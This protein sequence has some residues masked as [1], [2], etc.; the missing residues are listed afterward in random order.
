MK[1][2]K[3]FLTFIILTL[4]TEIVLAQSTL[5]IGI[6]K[7]AESQEFN[8]AAKHIK[9]EIIALTKPRFNVTFTE[10]NGN[11]NSVEI[12]QTLQRLMKNPDINLLI[13]VG[14]ISSNE[15]SKL[16]DYPK[17]LIAASILDQSLQKL[18][19]KS[20]K[21]TGVNNFTYIESLIR[22]KDDI[23]SF[24]QMFDV[25][26]AAVIIAKPLID[27]F[28]DIVNYIAE[29]GKGLNISMI[30]ADNHCS[31]A[32][33]KLPQEVDA[34]F[35]LPLF[36]SP[37]S[38][39]E[40]LLHGLN[41]KKIP[42]LAVSGI[43]YL[44]MGATVTFTPQYNFQQLA[45]QTALRILK[46]GEGTNLSKVPVS[47]EGIQRGPVINMAGIRV[48]KRFPQW[49]YLN[50]AILINTTKF[51]SGSEKN[52]RMV[53]AEALENNLQGKISDKDLLMAEK[54][55]RIAKANIYP[56]IEI[57]G[58]AIEL[59][60]NIVE[61]AM[62][63]KG[64][65]T[66]SGS[67]MLK[68]V[69]FSEAVFANITINKLMEENKKAF[70]RQTVL[71]IISNVSNAYIGLLF[72]KSNL[73]I[74]SENVNAT[75]QNLQM[76][77]AKKK[78][79]QSGIS[80][81]NRWISELNMNKM[82]LN[83]A[84]T[85][86]RTSMYQLNQILNK[87]I[88]EGIN[89]TDYDDFDKSVVSD[90]NLLKKIFENPILTEKYAGFIIEQ[91]YLNS[92]EL[93]QL[94]TAKEIIK[95]KK[96][97]YK[98]RLYLPEVAVWGGL[99]QAFIRN[100]TIKPVGMPVPPPPDDLTWNVGLKISLP[101]YEGGRT[102]TEMQKSKIELDKIN[103]QKEDLLN[104]LEAGIRANV[105]KSRASYLELELSTNAAKAAKDNF[106]VVQ[107]GYF[108]GVT[109]LVQLI[110]AQTVMTRTKHLANIAYYQ[111]IL[112]YLQVERLQGK[113]IFLSSAD[114]RTVYTNQLKN[115]L[116]DLSKGE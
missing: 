17:P 48:I 35:V 45:R 8:Q 110:D 92:P 70:N 104:K 84:Y 105:Q 59:S 37:D 53:I 67:A 13:T 66:L 87:P 9:S 56:Q 20:D 73:Q 43:K 38:E 10:F 46:V 18:P 90:I 116:Q 61:A 55:V 103:Y 102:Y 28:P 11:W 108:Q 51:P 91:M 4:T 62:G 94:S 34:V 54:N 82:K 79:G 16:A 76:A 7:D 50:E 24:S 49:S 93:K 98:R 72:S 83:D 27:N 101:I 14:F 32:L 58:T 57:S 47:I 99:D 81:V 41:E 23:R 88:D 2:I 26:K 80:D 78:A 12:K 77:K 115:Y 33:A 68:Q 42:S 40:K 71:E 97:L 22:L 106:K 113:Y 25:H 96:S 114:E 100:G 64:A 19:L 111:F 69:I 30:T 52:Y 86:Y 6:I 36:Q 85:M 60:E 109:N 3:F 65:F 107:D 95:R 112:D 89:I 1:N 15:A 44:Q 29:N 63:Q 75:M 74:Q 31:G 5:N 21:S 39:I